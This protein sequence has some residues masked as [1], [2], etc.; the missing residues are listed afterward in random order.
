MRAV[1]R[2]LLAAEAV[3]FTG[4]ALIHA[5][6]IVQGYEHH[7]ARTAESVLAAVLLAGLAVTAIA[8]ARTRS[9]G[10]LAQ[11]IALVGTLIGIFTTIVGIG[12]RSTPDIIYHV[13]MLALLGTGLAVTAR[14]GP[15]DAGRA[16]R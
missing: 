6:A 9:A 7:A 4:A 11:A 3:A 5:G 10:L 16:G 2:A 12:P 15:G 13:A 1:I 14:A 8:P